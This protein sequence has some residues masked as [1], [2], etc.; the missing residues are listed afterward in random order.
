MAIKIFH[1]GDIHIGMKFNRYIDNV[2][3]SLI[4]ARFETLENMI[5][6]SNELN[7]D[8][9]VVAGDLFNSIKIPQRDIKRVVSILNK[10]NGECVLVLP[11]NHDYDDGLN[12]L[13]IEFQKNDSDKILLL[14]E[15]KPYILKDYGLDI[16]VYPAPCDSKHSESNSLTWIK[17]EG[18]LN[19]CKYK[20]GIAHGALEGLSAD[21]QG[22][23]FYMTFDELNQ[24]PV[25]IW[26]IGHTH[27]RYPLNDTLKNNKIYNAGTHE[28]DGLDY[29]DEG[30]AWFI[31]LD[32]EINARRIIT[33]KYRFMDKLFEVDSEESLEEIKNFVEKNN[34]EKLI[35]R[36]NLNGRL[37]KEIYDDIR[38]FYDEIGNKV[39]DLVVDAN[40]LKEKIDKS[41]IDEEFTKGSFPYELLN[42]LSEDEEALQIAYELINKER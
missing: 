9:F 28:P 3:E 8:I 19:T 12:E 14:N 11:G 42:R 39:F 37:S 7:S 17:E 34:P 21:M 10:F 29:R 2:R 38:S 16:E 32:D 1:T 20:I 24:I 25:D 35:L 4:E 40:N 18:I 41:I 5:N 23:Y 27:V 30:S 13:W 22:Q 6:K 36:L 33:G 31:E 26:M 15:K